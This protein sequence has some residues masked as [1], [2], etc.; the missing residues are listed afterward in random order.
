MVPLAEVGST[1][2]DCIQLRLTMLRRDGETQAR[3]RLNLQVVEEYAELMREGIELP[4]IRACFDGSNYWITDGFHRVCAAEHLHLEAIRVEVFH[5]TLTDAQWESYGANAVHGL[6]RT[7]EDLRLIVGRALR[8]EKSANL[9]NCELAR[10]LHVSEKTIRRFRNLLS[11]ARAEDE[12]TAVR[13]GHEY[14]IH[15]ANI[16]KSVRT[17]KCSNGKANV[18]LE[19]R[20]AAD[21]LMMDREA[22][23]EVRRVLVI[24]R[25][26][27][28][29]APNPL[30]VLQALEHV[31]TEVKTP[32][33]ADL[34]MGAGRR[35]VE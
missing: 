19:R 28:Q 26:W 17:A 7:L 1:E 15:T 35:I 14:K 12:R 2:L 34:R 18:T 21:L 6:R 9:T 24:F 3:M 11:S 20:L 33:T 10:H 23:P 25:N 5:G 32:A 27:T 13:N 30:S 16:G 8:H 31:I 29:R 4:P 22:G